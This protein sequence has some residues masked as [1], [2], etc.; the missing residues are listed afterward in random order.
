[1]YQMMRYVE[2]L[3]YGKNNSV[4]NEVHDFVK[5]L[6]FFHG[7]DSRILNL[8]PL[9]NY[10]LMDPISMIETYGIS[11]LSGKI[12]H[13]KYHS[14]DS[15]C[16]TSF[17]TTLKNT[18]DH[19]ELCRDNEEYDVLELLQY[20]L[21]IGKDIGYSNLNIILIY[22]AR[23]Q[24][25]NVGCTIDI[26]D[27]KTTFDVFSSLLYFDKYI[28][29]A[30]NL[31]R[32]DYDNIFEN[33][34]L[35]KLKEKFRNIHYDFYEIYKNGVVTSKIVETLINLFTFE[36]SKPF[37]LSKGDK[38]IS[39]GATFC[40][41]YTPRILLQNHNGYKINNLLENYAKRNL[42]TKFWSVFNSNIFPLLEQ[43]K[44]R[45]FLLSNMHIIKK[46]QCNDDY[47]PIIAICNNSN[48]MYIS[49]N[50]YYAI[51]P[52]RIGTD[53]KI[54]ATDTNEHK[55]LLK[56]YLQTH[57]INCDVILTSDF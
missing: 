11:P 10:C 22:A 2:N 57:N 35:D 13:D 50:I 21:N 43:F 4:D 5:V 29:P 12:M 28:V 6:N 42:S 14:V 25:L 33:M 1:M 45:L 20:Q 38:Y 55:E 37:I 23:C 8:L 46:I 36:D 56:K 39:D 26:E 3:F 51:R 19:I 53:I 47:Y 49:D 16:S 9:T 27:I 54:L 15:R 48:L 18:L 24:M 52:I 34:T 41:K 7:T 31:K 40:P 32:K 30:T 44:Y 17:Y